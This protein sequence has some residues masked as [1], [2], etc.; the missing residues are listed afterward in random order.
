MDGLSTAWKNARLEVQS[1]QQRYKAQHDKRAKS[2]QYKIGD[3]VNIYMPTENQGKLRKLARP[4]YGPYRIEAVT[5]SNIRAV[6]VDRP[7]TEPIIVNLDH[8]C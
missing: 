1:A 4:F 8:Q 3:P 6:P 7:G 5:P 2:C